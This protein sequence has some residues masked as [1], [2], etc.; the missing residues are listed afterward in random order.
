MEAIH[1]K[2]RKEIAANPICVYMK[3]TPEAPQCGFSAQVVQI[4]KSYGLPFHAVDVLRDWDI[5]E[6]IKSFSN[7]PTI[8]QLYVKG[9]FIGGC[10]ITAELHRKGELQKILGN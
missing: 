3:G 4:L 9:Q 5:R 6:G 10:D 8:P 1:E 7:W 2:I